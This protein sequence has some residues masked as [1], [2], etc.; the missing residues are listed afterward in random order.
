MSDTVSWAEHAYLALFVAVVG[1]LFCSPVLVEPKFG[2]LQQL[3]ALIIIDWGSPKCVVPTAPKEQTNDRLPN[4]VSFCSFWSEKEICVL[5]WGSV[6]T[7]FVQ[8]GRE[9]RL[10]PGVGASPLVKSETEH[11][12]CALLPS[13]RREMRRSIYGSATRHSVQSEEGCLFSQTEESQ[14]LAWDTLWESVMGG[15]GVCCTGVLFFQTEKWV[16]SGLQQSKTV[17]VLT[18]GLGPLRRDPRRGRRDWRPRRTALLLPQGASLARRD[19]DQP[20]TARSRP[21]GQA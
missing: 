2:G 13:W 7:C 20:H 11:E 1:N 3:M 9:K 6:S 19:R 5:P 18:T 10:F 16:A 4:H 17:V 8:K 15:Y 12:T 21:D 14:D